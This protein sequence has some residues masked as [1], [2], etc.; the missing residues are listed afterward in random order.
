MYRKALSEAGLSSFS[1][2]FS[3]ASTGLPEQRNAVIQQKCHA[4]VANSERQV[5][6]T[7]TRLKQ[8]LGYVR[9]RREVQRPDLLVYL[10]EPAISLQTPFQGQDGQAVL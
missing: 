9:R 5:K 8:T 6:F 2:S 3:L 10:T 7:I 4:G 1:S